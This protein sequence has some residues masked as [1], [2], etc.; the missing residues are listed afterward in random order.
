MEIPE[1]IQA[2]LWQKFLFVASW[3]GVGT[4]VDAPIGIIRKVPETRQLLEQAM[5]EVLAV[6]HARNIAVPDDTVEKTMS[7]ADTLPHEGSTSLHRDIKE[8]K[9]SELEFWNG[10]VVRIGREVNVRTPIHSFIYSSLL[11]REL[12]AQGQIRF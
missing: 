12:R 5:T 6:A 3:G 9:P 11:P 2:A 1:D 4:L 8:G 10:A 7:F